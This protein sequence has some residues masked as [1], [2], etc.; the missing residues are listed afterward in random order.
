[1]QR[2]PTSPRRAEWRLIVL[3]PSLDGTLA[4]SRQREKR[5]REGHTHLQHSR[6]STWNE[7]VRID[8]TGL[9]VE[10]SLELVLE[11]LHGP[12]SVPLSVAEEARARRG[13]TRRIRFRG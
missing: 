10:K 13:R 12:A 4:R 9:G 3:L 6:C 8:T 1:V 7:T 5:V 11:R 2:V